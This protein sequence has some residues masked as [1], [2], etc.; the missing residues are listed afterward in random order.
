MGYLSELLAD[1]AFHK[2]F[3]YTVWVT[4]YGAL[5]PGNPFFVWWRLPLLL[6]TVVFFIYMIE[7]VRRGEPNGL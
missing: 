3:L 1:K 4:I 7:L 6:A 2:V 5:L